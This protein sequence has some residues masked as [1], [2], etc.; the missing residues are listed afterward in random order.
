MAAHESAG[1]HNQDFLAHSLLAG[2]HILGV[3]IAALSQAG[4]GQDQ[5]GGTGGHDGGVGSDLLHQFL[6]ICL[7]LRI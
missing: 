6:Q 7:D 5:R 1:A 2:E 4:D 3:H